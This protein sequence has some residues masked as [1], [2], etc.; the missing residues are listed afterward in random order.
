MKTPALILPLLSALMLTGCTSMKIKSDQVSDYDFSSVDT[1][2]WVRAPEKILNED[3]TYLS[4]D[5]QIALNNQLAGRSWNQVL[6][7]DKADIQIVYYIKLEEHQE[8]AGSPSPGNDEPRSTAGFTYNTSKGTWGYND[9]E[10]DLNVYSVEVGTL[11]LLIYD[12]ETG[13]KLWVGTL[14]TRLDRSTPVEKRKEMLTKIARRITAKI[15]V[16]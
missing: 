11:T 7:T 15:P 2:E 16:E 3:D 13:N 1:Y 12:A 5:V 9:Q 6:E 4:E 10:S 8:Y 14:E